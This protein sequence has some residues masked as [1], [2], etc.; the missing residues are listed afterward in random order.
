MVTSD[1]YIR[2]TVLVCCVYNGVI[3]DRRT[4]SYLILDIYTY[5]TQFVVRVH[6]LTCIVAGFKLISYKGSGGKLGHSVHKNLARTYVQFH[7]IHRRKME[8]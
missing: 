8:C 5:D 7:T 3:Q 2:L 4:R 6:I 1:L